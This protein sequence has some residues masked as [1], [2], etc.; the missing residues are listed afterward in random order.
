MFFRWGG[1]EF[2]V[3]IPSK[4]SAVAFQLAEKIRQMVESADILH[5]QKITVSIGGRIGM[6]R[7]IAI[8]ICFAA[9]MKRFIGQKMKAETA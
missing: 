2:V 4:N 1:E 5:E 7:M 6:A 8:W 9:W 3:Y